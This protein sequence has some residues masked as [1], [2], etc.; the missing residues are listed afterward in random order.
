MKV[1]QLDI[2]TAPHIAYL[3]GLF[4]QNVGI[5]QIVQ[6]GYTLCFAYKWQ[7]ER[8]V[9]FRSLWELGSAGLAESAH[10]LLDEADMVVHYNGRKFDIPVLNRDFLQHGLTPPANY[11][12]IDLYQTVRRRFKFA[13]NK[14]D[15]VCQALELGRKTQHKGMDLWREVMAGNE[16]SQRTM[17]RYNMQDVRL[18]ER[19]YF[20]VQPWVQQHP[21]R[22]L[23]VEDPSQ[24][25]CRNCGSTHV[26]KNGTE[27]RT[28][29]QY[30]RYVCLDCGTQQRGRISI[31]RG[32]QNVLV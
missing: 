2:E 16:K 13:S 4:D 24:P 8:G 10:E 5:N 15:Y 25:V 32:N 19:L 9:H 28:T 7:H 11:H 31:S 22:G 14:L 20:K 21:N 29:L 3:W 17:Q 30:Q 27:R 6:S 12:D 23:W 26:K 1:L 18:L